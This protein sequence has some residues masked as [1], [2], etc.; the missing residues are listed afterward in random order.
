[1]RSGLLRTY[2]TLAVAGIVVATSV[3]FAQ[4]GPAGCL[5]AKGSVTWGGPFL[6]LKGGQL[7][8]SD[9]ASIRCLEPGTTPCDFCV[10]AQI[11][12]KDAQGNWK[13]IASTRDGPHN[14][15]VKCQDLS[16]IL[17]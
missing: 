16:D 9:G 8:T 4:V 14:R 1:M 12:K 13:G 5:P 3:T 11:T 6:Q 17:P 7:V 2:V 15:Q 10:A